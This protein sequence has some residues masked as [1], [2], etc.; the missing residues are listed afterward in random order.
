MR[1]R[2]NAAKKDLKYNVKYESGEVVFEKGS[3]GKDI[4]F[5]LKGRAEIS[6]LVNEEKEIMAI[7]TTGDFFGEMAA[8]NDNDRCMTVTAIE[9]L[10]LYELSLNDMLGHM[11]SNPGMLKDVCSSLTSRLRDA[12]LKIRELTLKTVSS[13]E[14]EEDWMT[15]ELDKPNIIVVDDDLNILTVVKDL[16]SHDYSIFTATD[17]RSALRMME[18][19]D[20]AIALADYRMPE[21]S[22]IELLE[23]VKK[24]YPNAIRIVMSGS[25]DQATLMQAIKELHVHDVISKPWQAGE[26]EFTVARWI[27][28]YRKSRRLEEKANQCIFMQKELKKANKVIQNLIQEVRRLNAYQ[29]PPREL[30]QELLQEL[31]KKTLGN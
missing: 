19:H 5:I 18:L 4:Y 14:Y 28:Q 20:M 9:E 29:E 24:M 26:V 22:G 7:L 17:G 25:F 11:Q 27:A 3:K 30:V 12:N 23:N 6:Q 13:I 8:L 2:K 31:V 15:D 1:N 10:F 21:M 16:L